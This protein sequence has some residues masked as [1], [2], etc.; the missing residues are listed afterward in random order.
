[1]SLARATGVRL[2]TDPQRIAAVLAPENAR[3][4]HDHKH[5]P[6]LNHLAVGRANAWCHVVWKPTRLRGIAGAM[7]LA[8]SDGEL[9]L[10]HRHAVGS[11]LLLRH[12]LPYTRM[13]S[14]LL[15]QV[16]KRCIELA[17]YR[18]KVFKSDTLSAEDMTNLY[19][20]IVALDL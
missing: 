12:G 11:H 2:T 6:W 5:L 7:I 18:N 19:S 8:V 4:Y 17:G 16:P 13:E 1:L 14:R 3:T 20:E 10:R 15:P 9:F